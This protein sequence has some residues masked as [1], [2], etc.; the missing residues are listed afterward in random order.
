MKVILYESQIRGL[1][2]SPSSGTFRY[3][4]RKANQVQTIA[5]INAPKRTGD[6]AASIGS[7]DF[8]IRYGGYVLEARVSATARHALWVH[9]G[10]DRIFPQKRMNPK[11]LPFLWVH[12]PWRQYRNSKQPWV[13]GQNPQPFLADA[14]AAV[15]AGSRFIGGRVGL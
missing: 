9:E 5:R 11:L 6:L 7:P 13:E 8:N 4:R 14:L 15:M 3:V 1:V 10:T 2:S 12:P